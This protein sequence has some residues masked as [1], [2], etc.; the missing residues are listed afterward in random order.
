M[1]SASVEADSGLRHTPR[2]TRDSL[3]PK[4]RFGNE[5]E[6]QGFRSGKQYDPAGDNSP[7]LDFEL[8]WP[9]VEYYEEG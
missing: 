4:L 7:S 6:A 1:E 3:V 5:T 9:H 8:Y 2:E